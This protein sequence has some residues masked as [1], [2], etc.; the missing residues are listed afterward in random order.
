MSCL[1][2]YSSIKQPQAYRNST[3]VLEVIF[4]DAQIH[5]SFRG[6]GYPRLSAF[7]LLASV[8]LWVS[9]SHDLG[10]RG[11]RLRAGIECGIECEIGR[12]LQPTGAGDSLTEGTLYRSP[13]SADGSSFNSFSF[14]PL[15]Y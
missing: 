11:A 9:R 5:Q 14:R 7:Q 4:G 1:L 3:T 10:F 12:Y 6:I 13:T 8:G 15:S 2:I